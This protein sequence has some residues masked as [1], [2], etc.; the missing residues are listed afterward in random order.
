MNK[1]LCESQNIEAKTL[2]ADIFGH[3]GRFSPFAAQLADCQFD[4]GVQWWIYVSSNA[5]QR[6][7]KSVLLRL[8]SSKQR[9]ESSTHCHCFAWTVLFP[10]KKQC[11]INTRNSDFS[12]VKS[13][14]FFNSDALYM[15]SYELIEWCVALAILV[16][17]HLTPFCAFSLPFLSWSPH[18][19]DHC[20]VRLGS[21]YDLVRTLLPNTLLW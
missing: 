20:D 10:I 19:V 4:P 7:K 21:T 3:F 2:P 14:Q 6:M 11:I 8:N 12:I 1:I 18:L 17:G 9:S 13:Y 16:D 15:S 5:T